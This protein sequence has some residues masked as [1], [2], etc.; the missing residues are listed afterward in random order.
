[1]SK[2]IMFS[3]LLITSV[4]SLS[5]PVSSSSAASLSSWTMTGSSPSWESLVGG[6]RG[7]LRCSGYLLLE[8]VS[9]SSSL[10]SLSWV[11]GMDTGVAMLVM[12]METSPSVTGSNL[13]S[14]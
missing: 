11:P 7:M 6:S 10:P 13:S 14:T 12:E 9:T 1:M 5:S 8:L 2:I 4:A 3:T